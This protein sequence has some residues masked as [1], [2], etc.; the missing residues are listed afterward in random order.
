SRFDPTTSTFRNYSIA[1]G[2]P[3]GDL[4]G[5]D[6]CFKSRTGEMFFGGFSGGVAFHPESVVDGSY[7]PP[8][9][10]TDFQISGRAGPLGPQSALKRSITYTD[11]VTLRHEQNVFSLT[12]IALSY[13]NPSAIRYRYR[14]DGI[15]PDWVVVGSD[16]RTVTYTTLPAG[17]YTFRAQV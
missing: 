16:R 12:F 3:A 2:V 14:L 4:S 10:L 17:E 8:V 9:A 5:W 1:D 13:V 6:A 11:S 15:D 7:V